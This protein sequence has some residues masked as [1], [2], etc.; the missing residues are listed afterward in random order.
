MT[1]LLEKN[2]SIKT[3]YYHLNDS[4]SDSDSSDEI[5]FY[6]IRNDKF[7]INVYSGLILIVGI[8]NNN[9]HDKLYKILAE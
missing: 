3:G 5:L 4:D 6:I 2:D 9:N 8:D 1:A 7:K